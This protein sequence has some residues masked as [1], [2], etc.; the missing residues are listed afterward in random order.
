MHALAGRGELNEMPLEQ[1]SYEGQPPHPPNPLRLVFEL[2]REQY[3]HIAA[4]HIP[5]AVTSEQEEKGGGL[6]R[7]RAASEQASKWAAL[8]LFQA[9]PTDIHSHTDSSQP[10][11]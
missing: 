5:T 6:G 1:R 2:L 11:S 10:A 4:A 9:P 8:N 7:A 3:T